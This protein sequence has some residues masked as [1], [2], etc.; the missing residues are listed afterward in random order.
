MNTII[1]DRLEIEKNVCGE[2][3]NMLADK[4]EAILNQTRSNSNNSCL[5]DDE[6]IRSIFSNYVSITTYKKNSDETLVPYTIHG[7]PSGKIV[8]ATT[9]DEGDRDIHVILESCRFKST[10]GNRNL[11]T[12][13]REFTIPVTADI[14]EVKSSE[15]FEPSENKTYMHVGPA[16]H[17]HI[18]DVA[19]YK[20]NK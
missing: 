15:G 5:N 10:T 9:T 14:V 7:I 11:E 1:T 13:I 3:A 2:F 6:K 8:L 12:D 17:S 19:N 16:A 4:F 18:L 20:R